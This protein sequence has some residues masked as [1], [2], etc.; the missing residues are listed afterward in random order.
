VAEHLG[1]V[2]FLQ[3]TASRTVLAVDSLDPANV[4]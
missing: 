2:A 3:D 1:V 4:S